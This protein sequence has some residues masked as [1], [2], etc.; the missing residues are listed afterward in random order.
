MNSCLYDLFQIGERRNRFAIGLPTAFDEMMN[1][2]LKLGP[3]KHERPPS[4]TKKDL[5]RKFRLVMQNG[6]PGTQEAE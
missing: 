2:I 6:K 5:E 4:P 1:A 3:V